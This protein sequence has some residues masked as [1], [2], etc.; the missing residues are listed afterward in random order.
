MDER[1][2]VGAVVVE[3]HVHVEP[4]RQGR[5]DR[6]AESETFRRAVPLAG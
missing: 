6:V 3:H 1:C 2:L 4:Q 5:L